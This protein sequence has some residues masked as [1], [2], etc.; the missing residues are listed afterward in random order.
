VMSELKAPAGL[1]EKINSGRVSRRR[2]MPKPT[3]AA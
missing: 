3:H 1:C 2:I